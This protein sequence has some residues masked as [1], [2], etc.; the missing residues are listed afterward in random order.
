M[1]DAAA[2]LRA[3]AERGRGLILSIHQLADAARW[4]NRLVLLA[5]GHTI[6]EGTLAEL[7]ARAGLN[8]GGIEEVFLALA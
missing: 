4:C 6:A 2:L 3:H 5:D 1:R 8:E 7:R